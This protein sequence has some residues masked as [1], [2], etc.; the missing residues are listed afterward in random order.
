MSVDVKDSCLRQ[1]LCPVENEDKKDLLIIYLPLHYF[2]YLYG[3]ARLQL[4]FGAVKETHSFLRS[5]WI[6]VLNP[7]A[8]QP[9]IIL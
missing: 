6:L 4:I 1:L 7:L 8:S 3:M 9:V 5:A 2:T